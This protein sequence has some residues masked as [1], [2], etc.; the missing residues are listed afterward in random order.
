MQVS[1]NSPEALLDA[2]S[3][4]GIDWADKCAA[5]ELME[6]TKKSLLAQLTVSFM[7]EGG[8]KSAAEAKA[9]ASTEYQEHIAKMVEAR[10]QANTARVKYDSV[11]VYLNMLRTYEASRRA[12][13]QML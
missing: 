13:M 9:L 12:E 8:T 7:R 3:D 6:E 11:K 2:L 10:R 1:D 4:S 5:A